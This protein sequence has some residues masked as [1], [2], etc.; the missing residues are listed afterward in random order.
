MRKIDLFAYGELA[1][2]ES[3]THKKVSSVTGFAIK[4]EEEQ[5]E[6]DEN[7]NTNGKMSLSTNA[8]QVNTGNSEIQTRLN[9]LDDNMMVKDFLS[10]R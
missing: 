3:M 6:Q 1:R 5:K 9:D 8:S 2:R 4:K 7:A 10:Y